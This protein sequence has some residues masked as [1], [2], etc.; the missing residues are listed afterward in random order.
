MLSALGLQPTTIVE[1]AAFARTATS[2]CSLNDVAL[3]V[4][5]D[6]ATYT[7]GQVAALFRI[8][9]VCFALVRFWTVQSIGARNFWVSWNMGTENLQLVKLNLVL[10]PV[11]WVQ[12]SQGVAPTVI[13]P[14]CRGL[15]P[16]DS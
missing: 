15:T 12:S 10:A 4:G 16:V 6:E 2:D 13:P 1:V 5:T 8:S 3:V 11:V 14:E 7:A 9:G